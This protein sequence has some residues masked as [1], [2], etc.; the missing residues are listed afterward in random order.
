MARD[1]RQLGQEGE[2]LAEQFLRQQGLTPVARN[3]RG[4]QGE[5]DLIMRDG[6][7]L[8]FIEV[9]QRNTNAFGTPV[10]LVTPSKQK[11]IIQTALS[12]VQ[13]QH[14]SSLQELRF[15]VVGILTKPGQTPQINWIKHAF[16]G[17]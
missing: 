1:G 9:K 4:T 2:T 6:P 8:V 13:Q 12:F 17:Q 16:N 5:I 10:E 3:V 15:D 11:K 14:I 7:S